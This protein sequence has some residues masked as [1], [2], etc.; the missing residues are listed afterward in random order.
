MAKTHKSYRLTGRLPRYSTVTSAFANGM[1]L[2]N[3]DI[4]E[5]YTKTMINYDIDDTGSNIKP[6]RGRNKVQVLDYNGEKKLGAVTL[7]DYIYS[8]N[9]TENEINDLKDLVLSYGE[10]TDLSIYSHNVDYNKP[11]YTAGISTTI[12]SNVYA[13][14]ENDEWYIVEPGTITNVETN[15]FWALYYNKEAEEFNKITNEDIGYVTSR[16]IKNA[17]A[18][19]KPFKNEVGRP[20]GTVMNNELIAFT[21]PRIRYINYTSNPERNELVNLSAPLLTKLNIVET[22]NGYKIHRNIIEPREINPAEA[23][24]SGY[25]ML[26]TN[27]YTLKDTL[28]GTVAITGVLPYHQD[29]TV[30]FNYTLGEDVKFRIYYQYPTTSTVVKYKVEVLDLTN[31]KSDW[32]VL[33]EWTNSFNGGDPFYY[34]YNVKYTN[35]SLRFTIRI[36]DDTTTEYPY[37]TPPIVVT[38]DKEYSDLEG[39]VFDLST[40]LGMITWQGCVGLYGVDSAKNVIFFSDVDDPSYFPYPYNTIIFDNEILAVY[41]YLDYLLVVTVDSIWLIT[42]GTTIA[43][44]VQ[45]RILA[46]LHIPEID[47][48]NLVVLKDQI[49]FKTDSQFYVLKPNQYTSDATDLKNYINSIAIANYTLSF[50]NETVDLLNKVFVLTWQRLTKEYKKQIRFEDFDVLDTRSIIRN[51]EVHYIYTI[52]PKLTDNIILDKLNLHLVYNTIS[53]SWRLYFVAIGNDSVYYNPIL[54]RNKQS[55]LFYEF[56]PYSYNNECYIII[57]EQT[58]DS[59]TD[60]VTNGDWELTTEYNNYTYIDTG[61]V[62]LNSI[63]TKRFREVQFNLMNL[64]HNTIKFYTDFILDGQEREHATNYEVQH[65]TDINDPDYGLIYVIPIETYNLDLVGMTTL[66][67]EITKD[68]FWAID[69]S[70]Y[71]D[72][73]VVTVRFELQGRGRRGAIRMLNTSLQRYELAGL[74]WVYRNMNAR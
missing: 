23:R 55:G 4:P 47:A 12:D 42:P 65:I 40:C 27:P 2:T 53:R 58:Y 29:D 48:I 18:F 11:I 8:Y 46:N 72:L 35:Q 13:K 44:S 16:T 43:T 64:T 24:T 62:D 5:G 17:Y 31:N 34:T 21:G 15:E 52:V 1:Y 66:A 28:G 45:K 70:K 39:K 49:F 37:P 9:K 41:N 50:Q 60:N 68:D 71:P 32:E 57:S 38:V 69:L 14:D 6:R 3:Q 74:N 36:D 30:L 73:N 22:D 33:E 20:V 51:E 59:L 19:Q 54:Y 67:D 26:S 25:N 56:I 7:T 61:N 10:Y 63:F